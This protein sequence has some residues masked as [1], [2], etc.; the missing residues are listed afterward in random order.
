MIL[1]YSIQIEWHQEYLEWVMCYHLIEKAQEAIDEKE[2]TE[3]RKEN[4]E[5]RI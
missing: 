5:S 3:F 1:K 2:A 4:V